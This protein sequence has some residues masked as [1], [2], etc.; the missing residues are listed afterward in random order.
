MA[1][2]GV[3]LNIW[4][5][6]K[7]ANRRNK[8]VIIPFSGE[9]RVFFQ[10]VRWWSDDFLARFETFFKWSANGQIVFWSD[11]SCFSNGQMMVRWFSGAIRVIFQMVSQW[12]DRFLERF[13]FFFKWSDDGQMI[14]WRDSSLLTTLAK[15]SDNGQLNN[16]LFS[17][18]GPGSFSQMVSWEDGLPKVQCQNI[19]EKKIGVIG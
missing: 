1:V 11:S 2:M 14:F 17:A 18:V 10:M 3:L 6:I 19:L 9:I 15:W 7:P 8:K 16:T 5:N 12:S 13:E 4:Y